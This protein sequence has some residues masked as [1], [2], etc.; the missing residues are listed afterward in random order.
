MVRLIR[1]SK[2]EQ[3]FYHALRLVLEPLSPGKVK[4]IVII[5][6]R[7]VSTIYQEASIAQRD[8]AQ[9]YGFHQQT[10][11]LDYI[12]SNYQANLIEHLKEFM[13]KF[14][15]IGFLYHEILHQKL[16][17]ADDPKLVNIELGPKQEARYHFELNLFAEINIINWKY[18]PFKTPVRKRYKDLDRQANIFVNEEQV[19]ATKQ[20]NK[21]ITVGDWALFSLS[22]ANKNNIPLLDNYKEKFWLKIGE[23][24]VDSPLRE[25]FSE[26]QIGNIFFTTNKTL[27]EYFSDQLDSNYNFCIEILDIQHQTYFCFNQFKRHFRVKTNKE[28]HQKLVEV[29]SYRNDLSQRRT[30][31]EDALSTMLSKHPFS[32]P[33]CLIEQQQKM[34]LEVM[35]KNPDYNVYRTQKDFKQN[36]RK[37]AE[38]QVKENIFIDQLAYHENI[39]LD[40]NDVKNY[41]NFTKRPRMKEFIY[42]PPPPTRIDGQEMPVVAQELKQACLREKALNHII[43]HLTKK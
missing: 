18:L 20:V 16:T 29:F 27:Q 42:F 15:V 43:Y 11:P 24:E 4:A 8:A 6:A 26:K 21:S 30:M 33:E 40:N 25:I 38:K 7:F 9:T 31:A 35:Y 37:L 3:S 32:P 12:T 17:L 34:I 36:V 39:H 13:L 2:P 5:P 23:E 1:K 10:V 22:L 14:F 28:M 41:L 19:L